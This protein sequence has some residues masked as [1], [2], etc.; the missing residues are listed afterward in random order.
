MPPNTIFVNRV[1]QPSLGHKEN[2]YD[3]AEGSLS[4]FS[5]GIPVKSHLEPRDDNS[6]VWFAIKFLSTNRY[7][8]QLILVLN[9]NPFQIA[10]T[11]R[12]N[13]SLHVTCVLFSLILLFYHWLAIWHIYSCETSDLMKKASTAMRYDSDVPTVTYT[14]TGVV[15]EAFLWGNLFA[16]NFTALTR[17]L[18]YFE[19]TFCDLKA[20]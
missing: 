13:L 3:A 12:S 4:S 20:C 2:L 19:P 18:K 6:F 14:R 16:V 1:W 15:P 17:K 8:T 11:N 10:P 5:Q 7:H 9:P